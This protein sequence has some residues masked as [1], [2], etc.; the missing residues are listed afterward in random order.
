MLPQSRALNERV[1]NRLISSGL[2]GFFAGV[3]VGASAPIKPAAGLVGFVLAVASFIILLSVVATME[4]LAHGVGYVGGPISRDDRACEKFWNPEKPSS[5][6][7][8]RIR[9]R[10]RLSCWK[11][12]DA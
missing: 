8:G 6:D 10:T 11:R 9:P 12:G 2:N 7:E 1:L 5:L 4:N 3:T